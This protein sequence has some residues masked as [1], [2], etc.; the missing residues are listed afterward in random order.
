MRRR[1]DQPLLTGRGRFV[2]DLAFGGR[3]HV[4]RARSLHAHARIRSID[5]AAARRAPGVVAVITAEDL[6]SIGPVP[7]MRL[8]PGTLV[9]EYPLLAA[10][11][12]RAQGVPVAAVVADSTYAATDGVDRLVVDYE[13]IAGVADPDGALAPGA[14]QV[15]PVSRDNRALAV[16]WRHG[17]TERAF[18][19]A[20][21]RV[22]LT[23]QHPRLCGGP[24][25]PHGAPRRW[26]AVTGELTVWTST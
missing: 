25:E 20:A 9:P 17:D 7:L 26:D 16:A 6:G 19:A 12:V 21:H 1:E 11:V 18:R 8:A 24:L 23:L 14:P 3:L 15:V 13:P 2:D 10:D 22:T 4:N 5:A